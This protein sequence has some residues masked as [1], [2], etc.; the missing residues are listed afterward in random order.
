MDHLGPNERLGFRIHEQG[1]AAP[2]RFLP[3]FAGSDVH[4]GSE[5]PRLRAAFAGLLAGAHL[6]LGLPE[7]GGLCTP[8]R[9]EVPGGAKRQREHLP[10]SCYGGLERGGLRFG[11]RDLCEGPGDQLPREV[12]GCP[13][14]AGRGGRA[15][16]TCLVCFRENEATL[17]RVFH[18]RSENLGHPKRCQH[19]TPDH[20]FLADR[21]KRRGLACHRPRRKRM[22]LREQKHPLG[23]GALQ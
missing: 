7:G 12:W 14:S 8:L 6:G 16:P 5:T 19:W 4:C 1:R 21:C 15:L 3:G 23:S 20:S 2:G 13:K 17:P 9:P 11:G 22:L 10:S 18:G